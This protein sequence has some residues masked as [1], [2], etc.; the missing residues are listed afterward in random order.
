MFS[1]PPSDILVSGPVTRVRAAAA[2]CDSTL[3][4]TMS[5]TQ[6]LEG[7]EEQRQVGGEGGLGKHRSP[8]DKKSQV[9]H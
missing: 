2:N 8:S 9:K 5:A 3:F 1:M 7:R 4:Q 6:G